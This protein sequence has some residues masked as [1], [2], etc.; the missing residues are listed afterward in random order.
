MYL[1]RFIKYHICTLL[2][3]Y[4][5][6]TFMKMF[7]VVSISPKCALKCKL[8]TKYEDKKPN[9]HFYTENSHAVNLSSRNYEKFYYNKQTRMHTYCIYLARLMIM[10]VIYSQ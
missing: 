10:W 7:K 8:F 6:M 3:A 5:N 4:S 9:N 2:N 1:V